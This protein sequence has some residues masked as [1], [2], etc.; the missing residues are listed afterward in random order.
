MLDRIHKISEIVAAFALVASLLFV[1]VQISQNTDATRISNAQ[2]GFQTWSN[3]G[4]AAATDEGLSRI[5]H[6][7]LYPQAREAFNIDADVLRLQSHHTAVLKV[8]EV[9]FLQWQQGYLSDEVWSGYRTTLVGMFATHEGLNN[10]W[11][12]VKFTY[13]P[14]FIAYIDT[15][16]A[17][18][19]ALR[20]S[21]YAEGFFPASSVR[22]E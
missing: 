17:E 19:A 4:M 12:Q 11:E 2:A 22:I 8:N 3:Q 6:D 7:S 13:A 14:A 20:N 16:Q 5:L 15:L 10:I 21:N 18:G 9:L 1:G